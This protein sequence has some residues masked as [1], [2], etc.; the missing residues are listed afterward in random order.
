MEETKEEDKS[1]TLKNI[2]FAWIIFIA[3][4]III[5]L[6]FMFTPLWIASILFLIIYLP[7]LIFILILKWIKRGF[8]SVVFTFSVWLNVIILIIPIFGGLLVLDLMSFSQQFSSSPKYIVLDDANSLIFGINLES[9]SSSGD[10]ISGYQI[11]TQQQLN[12]IQNEINQNNIKDKVVFLIKKDVFRNINEI[13]VKELSTTISKDT[14]FELI[15]SDDPA[16]IIAESVMKDS[17]QGLTD[18][19][20][21]EELRK[22]FGNTDQ[23]K[24]L[25]VLLLV[26]T[27]LEREGP[28]YF[29]DELKSG[30]IKIYPEKLSVKILINLLPADLVTSFLPTIPR[31]SDKGSQGSNSGAGFLQGQFGSNSKG[32]RPVEYENSPKSGD[33]SKEISK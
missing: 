15:K 8:A 17:T 22:Q 4:I 10:L 24:S 25:A 2:G 29:I 21:K 23:V 16:K 18:G 7:V 14:I 11:L 32:T 13:P 27:A 1:K 12:N 31:I 9:Q 20:I 26:E 6:T 3:T 28:K 5:V 30:N 33:S 19:L